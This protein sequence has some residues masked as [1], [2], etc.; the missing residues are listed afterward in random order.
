MTDRVATFFP[1][2]FT[3]IAQ[4]LVCTLHILNCK[5]RIRGWKAAVLIILSLPIMVVLNLSHSEQPVMIWLVMTACCLAAMFIYLRLGTK[6]DASNTI[7]RWCN[8]L[9][10]S[11]LIAALAWM[12]NGYFISRDVV[13]FPDIRASQTIMACTYAIALVPLGLFLNNRKKRQDSVLKASYG[14]VLANIMIALGAYAL[15]NIS[16]IT[17]ANSIFGV[18]MRG[19]VL[20][21]RAVSDF[22]GVLGL[23]AISEFGYSI[24]LKMNV[25]A[26]QGI[27]DRQY[28][29]Y[30]Q[31]KANNE[32]IQQVYHD[33]KHLIAY[34]RSASNSN[35]YE[36]ELQNLEETVSNYEV[37]YNSGNAVLDVVLG[38][39][40]MIC[41]S[42]RITMECYVDARE[43]GFMEA[44]P[45]CSI[46]GNA[47][48]NAIEY[49]R[50]IEDA[51]K[52]LIKVN[53]F[54][55]NQFLMI[56]ISNY[57]EEKILKS[58]E[59]PVSTKNNPEMHGYGIRGIRL[60][61]EEYNGHMS[62]KQENNWFIVS[63]LIPIPPEKAEES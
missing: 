42:E 11:E 57:C 63:A 28:E 30:R 39:K 38:S 56:S 29:Q 9:M 51:E 13:R 12:L 45:I 49:E 5:K 34:I 48:D 2:E 37:Q 32:Q 52:R 14:E 55:E 43:M 50:G 46:F 53:V 18:S 41:K 33:I 16:F 60:A 27:V 8:T 20:L 22:S 23:I 44:V 15:S 31:Y 7:I 10:Q 36:K 3:A 21:V 26:L 1:A 59:D 35:K 58:A 19:G 4:W 47:L 40:K 25:S 24:R 62:I 6:E 54:S 61:V 17:P